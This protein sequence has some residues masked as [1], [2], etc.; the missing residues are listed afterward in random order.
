MAALKTGK[1]GNDEDGRVLIQNMLENIGISNGDVAI[2]DGSGESRY[3]LVTPKAVVQLLKAAYSNK[4]IRSDFIGALPQYGGGGTLRLR[5]IN[6]NYGQFVYA[7]TGTFKG[8]SALAGYY[9]PPDGSKYAF[10]IMSNNSRLSWDEAK[11]LEDKILYI[12]LSK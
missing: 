10:A 11:T 2:Y 3:N 7:K 12:L 4:K 6:G 1:P 8:V 9:L 5:S